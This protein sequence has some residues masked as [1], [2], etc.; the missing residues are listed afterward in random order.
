MA[1]G[2]RVTQPVN[3]QLRFMF[4]TLMSRRR[5]P[6][7]RSSEARGGGRLLWPWVPRGQGWPASSAFLRR[8][9]PSPAPPGSRPRRPALRYRFLRRNSPRL[10]KRR[11]GC[12]G[13]SG[14]SGA[15]VWHFLLGRG[16]RFQSCAQVP[17]LL[18]CPAAQGRA[19]PEAPGPCVSAE[20]LQKQS[21]S[22]QTLATGPETTVTQL[23]ASRR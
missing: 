6:G 21:L 1:S 11:Y 5:P 19:L 15:I 18:C 2:L 13:D 16:P 12:D 23:L 22:Q 14:L 17:R 3:G 4:L 7:S 20:S 8:A 9:L 10:R